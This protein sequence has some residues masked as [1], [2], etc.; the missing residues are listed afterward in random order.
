MGW[1]SW[2]KFACDGLNE[3]VVK[4]MADAF[5]TSGMK[6]AGYQYVNL[7]DCWMNGRDSA[8]G[9]INVNTSKFPG[10]MKALADY[11]HGKGLK[12]GLYSTPNTK[13]CT[14]LYSGYTGGVGSIGHE[15]ADAQSYADW[16]IDYLKY[17]K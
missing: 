4:K 16:G 14:G 1:N 15:T 11:V 12:I 3:S 9:K 7:D 17:D 6:D 13:T 5:V 2:N 8:T 10:G